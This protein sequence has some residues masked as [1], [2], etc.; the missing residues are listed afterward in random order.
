MEDQGRRDQD[1]DRVGN[2]GAD[3]LGTDD[4]E[5]AS[6]EDTGHEPSENAAVDDV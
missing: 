5:F 1:R 6:V 4:E 3:E 2:V